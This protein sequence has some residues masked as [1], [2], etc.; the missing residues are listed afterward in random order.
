M[1]LVNRVSIFFLVA[2]VVVL[3]AFSVLL[4]GLVQHNLDLQFNHEL[5]SALDTLLDAVDVDEHDIEWIP[6]EH[7]LAV[8]S[9]E[10]ADKARWA[11]ID[12]ET[13]TLIDH[14]RNASLTEQQ[15]LLALARNDT[16]SRERH[17]DWQF[18]EKQLEPTGRAKDLDPGEFSRVRVIVARSNSG[19]SQNLHQLALVV[20]CLSVGTLV[21]AAISGRWYCL[22]ALK[23]VRDMAASARS[24]TAADFHLRLPVARDDGDELAELGNAFN[25]LLDQLQQAFERQ[26]RFAGDAA[27]QLRTPLTV[28]QGQIDVALRRPRSVED[29]QRTLSV[30][31]D[32]SIEMHQIVEGLLYLAR[33]AGDASPPAFETGNLGDWMERQAQRWSAQPRGADLI[34]D[35]EPGI[36]F[37]TSWGLFSQLLDN[38]V[39]NACKYSETGTPIRVRGSLTDRG[40]TIDVEDEGMGISPEDQQALFV[41]FFRAAVV[42]QSGI[43]GVGLGLPIAQRIANVLGGELECRSELGR[44][45]R[46][47]VIL[48]ARNAA[49]VAQRPLQPIVETAAAV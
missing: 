29:Y 41:P 31:R 9:E 14:S 17:R 23:P 45:S 43:A 22:K 16:E 37:S 25:D 47:R 10:G 30:L 20:F 33:S 5:R 32:Q 1:T 36:E 28:L 13:G 24:V 40:V 4:Y 27:H 42:R 26:Q 8:G 46:F 6:N 21:I 18:I 2:M 38:L 11:V 44:G 15:D 19:L 34:V 35:V 3:T 7:T 39:S 48:P 12:D 49:A